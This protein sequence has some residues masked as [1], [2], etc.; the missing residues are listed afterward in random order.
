MNSSQFA[1]RGYVTKV[2]S[3][4]RQQR[5]KGKARTDPIAHQAIINS[6][7][8]MTSD[9]ANRS[10]NREETYAPYSENVDTY[11]VERGEWAM[12]RVGGFDNRE[13]RKVNEIGLAISVFTC[14][15]GLRKGDQI[16]AIG[17]IENPSNGHGVSKT[18]T[19]GGSVR[20]GGTGTGRNTG[21]LPI[22]AG[23]RVF[24][25]LV[26]YTIMQNG[27]PVPAIDF[28][29]ATSAEDGVGIPAD[30]FYATTIVFNAGT[31]QHAFDHLRRD[32]VN[33]IEKIATS[34]N[35]TAARKEVDDILRAG[36]LMSDMPLHQAGHLIASKAA[37]HFVEEV[38]HNRRSPTD[39]LSMMTKCVWNYAQES[40]NAYLK[41][42]SQIKSRWERS[43]RDSI[44]AVVVPFMPI[45]SQQ[46]LA[47]Q[48]PTVE[49]RMQFLPLIEIAIEKLQHLHGDWM[50]AQFVG[51]ALSS[52]GKGEQFHIALRMGKS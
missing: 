24:L 12:A 8:D 16:K 27:E 1:P 7:A 39:A 34:A 13:G 49:I 10:R 33:K 15:N 18:R 44:G 23:D 31:A 47:A 17:L 25:S 21:P 50:D 40:Y 51:T 14:L 28:D 41:D 6:S 32:I 29:T 43:L 38:L 19:N 20:W 22:N 45:V 35:A 4:G 2:R 52:G 36:G 42:V 9:Q 30:K 11:R 5:F 48:D 3:S 37:I 46:S 26:P